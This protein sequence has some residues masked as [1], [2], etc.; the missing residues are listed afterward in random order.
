MGSQRV[1]H[2]RA[3]FTIH[4]DISASSNHRGRYYCWN[5]AILSAQTIDPF[6]SQSLCPVGMCGTF[7]PLVLYFGISQNGSLTF[8]LNF[9]RFFLSSK[10]RKEWGKKKEGCV[11]LSR[12]ISLATKASYGF[13]LGIPFLILWCLSWRSRQSICSKSTRGFKVR[14]WGKPYRCPHLPSP[15]NSLY[16]P[17]LQRPVG[18]LLILCM[19][20]L[21]SLPSAPQL[22][23]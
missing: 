10:V 3:T 1:T 16:T 17:H 14:G 7:F 20:A 21:P 11:R 13:S 22:P 18:V 2:E 4:R 8:K 23:S 12:Y 5:L 15:M 6:S 9:L 19:P